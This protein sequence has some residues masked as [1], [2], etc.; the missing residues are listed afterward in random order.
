MP[1]ALSYSRLSQ[2]KECPKRFYLNYILKTFPVEQDN[3][4]FIR[5]N[6]VHKQLE[7]YALDLY[8]KSQGMES[9]VKVPKL[10]DA[11]KSARGII[12]SLIATHDTVD[13]EQ[14]LCVNKE[15][16]PVS[17]FSKPTIAYYRVIVDL[18]AISNASRSAVVIDW[19]TGKVREYDD[20]DTGQLH[21]TAAT[22]FELLPEVDTIKTVYM[23]VDHKQSIPRTFKREDLDVLKTPFIHAYN[24]VNEDEDFNPTPNPHCTYCPA[25]KKQCPYARNM[26]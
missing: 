6:A 23:F 5:G 26:I 8:V 20:S 4:Y 1:I 11:A 10:S 16:N 19:K 7:M 12:K 25:T 13:V 3:P 14:Q 18:L 9:A 22:M 24:E 17:W 15:W 21:L 2:Y